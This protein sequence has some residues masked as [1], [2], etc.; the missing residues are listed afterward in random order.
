VKIN[1]DD[2]KNSKAFIQ[3]WFLKNGEGKI[4][5]TVSIMGPSTMVP[6][7]VIAFWIGE[8]TNWDKEALES[9]QTLTEFY[10]YTEILNIP[11]SYP[12]KNNS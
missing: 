9:I 6:C 2:Y 7:I 10:D 5:E 3:D 12:K 8:V 11:D 4:T 1:I